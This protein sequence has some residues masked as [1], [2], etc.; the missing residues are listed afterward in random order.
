MALVILLIRLDSRGQAIFIQERVG[1]EGRRFRM[2]KFRT[3]YSNQDYSAHET[4]MCAF[5]KGEIGKDETKEAIYKPFQEL[6]VTRV[7]RVLRRTS[8]D[9]LPQ[10][11]NVLKGDM[12]IVGPRPNVPW[13]VDVYKDWHKERLN[14]TPGI[15]G[16]AQV[17][18]RSSI[19]FDRIVKYD[20]E[21]IENQNLLLDL[22]ILWWTLVSVVGGEGVQ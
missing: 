16:L 3:L 8:L 19:S 17:K 21:Y 15:T 5:V 12:S 4:F 1:R 11:I 10:I 2:Y 7:G 18:G 20:I 22:K 14:A 9:E 13:E 6:L